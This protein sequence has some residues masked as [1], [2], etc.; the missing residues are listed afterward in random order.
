MWP[1]MQVSRPSSKPCAHCTC[2]RIQRKKC[3]FPIC[4]TMSIVAAKSFHLGA[5]VVIALNSQ[6]LKLEPDPDLAFAT[7]QILLNGAY[8]RLLTYGLKD[9]AVLRTERVLV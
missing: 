9:V 7:R 5:A 1:S 6:E 2:A 4:I 3:E 8:S